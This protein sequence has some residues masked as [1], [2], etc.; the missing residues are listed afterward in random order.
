MDSSQARLPGRGTGTGSYP[1]TGGRETK[2]D[3]RYNFHFRGDGKGGGQKDNNRATT[4]LLIVNPRKS[5]ER[6]KKGK[7][8]LVSNSVVGWLGGTPGIVI[9]W[10]ESTLSDAPLNDRLNLPFFVWKNMMFLGQ[11]S[12]FWRHLR[13]MSVRRDVRYSD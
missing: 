8:S 11:R 3:N 1:V 2:I 12:I 5:G 7:R 4:S 13:K 10:N 9:R 6:K